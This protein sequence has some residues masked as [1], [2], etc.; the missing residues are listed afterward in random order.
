MFKVHKFKYFKGKFGDKRSL[1]PKWYLF[2]RGGS[3]LGPP[4]S[5]CPEDQYND[6]IL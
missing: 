6:N 2:G 5:D 3:S 1:I 4:Q